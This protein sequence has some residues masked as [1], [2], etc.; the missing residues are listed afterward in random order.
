MSQLPI[1][2]PTAPVIRPRRDLH[3]LLGPGNYKELS[4]QT[5]YV[6]Q[7]IGRALKGTAGL[8]MDA[9]SAIADA[10]GVTMDELR[11]YIEGGR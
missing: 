6:Y 5:G 1:T 7:H 9:M 10:A 2:A 11:S 8:S 3:I 4:R